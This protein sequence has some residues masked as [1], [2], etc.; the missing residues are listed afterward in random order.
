MPTV[1]P[2]A[3][4]DPISGLSGL[5]PWRVPGGKPKIVWHTTEGPNKPPW[6]TMRSGIPHFTYHRK[7]GECWQHLDLDVAAYTMMAGDYSPN[8]DGGVTIQIEI[9]GYAR[10][11]ATWTQAECDGL[12][13]LTSWIADQIGC[14]VEFPH[15]FAG[16]DAY[17]TN[18][19]ARLSW[20]EWRAT[21]G[22]VGHQHAPWNSH[23]DP[24]KVPV[25]KMTTEDT[26]DYDQLVIDVA[27]RVNRVL[28]D[29]NAEG[30]PTG[31]DKD[32]PEFAAKKIREIENV[33]RRVEE[34]VDRL[35]SVLATLDETTTAILINVRD[36]DDLVLV[37]HKGDDT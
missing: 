4:W 26:V 34:K 14:P 19:V 10:D 28:G 15:A 11:S 7:T 23:W 12:M 2:D 17:G 6:E 37:R 20:E 3:T 27:A 24:G 13:E 22:I 9:V 21:T 5:R 36:L 25:E 30:L 8:S 29:Y 31:P 16:D 35:L 33:V 1:Y 32:N 18:G